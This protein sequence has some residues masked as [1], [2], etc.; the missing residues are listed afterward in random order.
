MTNN[1][2]TVRFAPDDYT[3]G[4]ALLDWESKYTDKKARR[5]ILFESIYVVALL[6]VVPTLVFLIWLGIPKIWLPIDEGGYEIFSRYAY[7]W[8]GGTFGGVLFVMKWLYHSVAKSIWHLDRRLWRLFTPHMSG[9]FA[10]AIVLLIS[11]GIV[12]ILDQDTLIKPSVCL[13]LGFIVGY[14]SD[15]AV[16]KLAEVAEVLLGVSRKENKLERK[17]PQLGASSPSE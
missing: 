5:N 1:K 8:L 16:A 11:S 4:R 17:D 2:H 15:F 6:I 13:S 7:A 14:F 10:F 9:G 3:D 12:Q